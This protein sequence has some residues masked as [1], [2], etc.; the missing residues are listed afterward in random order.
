MKNITADPSFS[1]KRTAAASMI[2]LC[3]LVGAY[4]VAN[5]G[6]ESDSPLAVITS[7]SVISESVTDADSG[8]LGNSPI[9]SSTEIFAD[10]AIEVSAANVDDSA[11]EQSS[12]ENDSS[13][14]SSVDT[15]TENT[16]VVNET[17]EVA[18]AESTDSALQIDD[19]VEAQNV[20][21]ETVLVEDDRATDDASATNADADDSLESQIEASDQVSDDG[22][23]LVLASINPDAAQSDQMVS[24]PITSQV[25]DPIAKASEVLDSDRPAAALDVSKDIFTMSLEPDTVLPGSD[26]ATAE[27]N[28]AGDQSIEWVEAIVKKHDT[29]SQLFNRLGLSSREAFLIAEYKESKPLLRIRPGDTIQVHIENERLAILRYAIDRFKT[30]QIKSADSGYTFE[31]LE[32]E[33]EIRHSQKSTT[34]WSSVLSA[35][36]EQGIGSNT[37]YEM[38]R[39]FG[40]QVDFAKDIQPG[41]RFSLI[42]EELYLGDDKV[43]EGQILAAELVTGNKPLRA[44][45]HVYEDGSVD[46]F[47][48]N[49]DGIKGSFLRTP[50]KFGRVSSKFSK[51]RFHPILKKWRAHKGV[52]Y[53][54]PKGTPIFSTGDGV[55]RQAT[56]NKGYGKTVVIR[57]GG[58]FET[59]YAHMSRFAKGIKAGKRVKQGDIIGYVGNTGWAT[60]HHLH[61]EFRVNGV[62][63]NPLTVKLPKSSPIDKKYLSGF[64]KQALTLAADLDQMSQI[65]VA[66]ADSASVQ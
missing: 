50:M 16:E 7:D 55:V 57:H 3:A 35:A 22:A 17:P 33:P 48:P 10:I 47:A 2:G 13:D 58:Q 32:K 46:Y 36:S 39:L 1:M 62:H 21:T 64:K 25:N 37:V 26:D 11:N 20:T 23:Q 31:T 42:Y 45:R 60:G 9:A 56:R 6:E 8:T 34:I 30:L 38:I 4:A 59:L 53:A 43:G 5:T 15:V 40:W 61:Y 66:Q 51:K 29:L 24:T 65:P 41:D 44:I 63:K 12:S 52:D 14:L 49:G 27:E 28:G 19:P 18:V 54:A